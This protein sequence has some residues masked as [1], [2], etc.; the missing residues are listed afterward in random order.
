MKVLLVSAEWVFNNC[1]PPFHKRTGE[2]QCISCLWHNFNLALS[3]VQQCSSWFL[4]EAAAF[5]TW[6][7]FI[8][9]GD[10]PSQP[11]R[12]RALGVHSACKES[13]PTSVVSSLQCGNEHGAGSK[14]QNFRL[15]MMKAR[16]GN[17]ISSSIIWNPQLLLF[18]HPNHTPSPG[19]AAPPTPQVT[20]IPSLNYAHPTEL[21]APGT[22]KKPIPQLAD[23]S[24]SGFG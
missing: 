3:E 15:Q 8:W 4:V 24:R 16:L 7:W 18:P 9:A 13:T 14:T 11:Q 10:V 21:R 19:G 5:W 12:H 2:V 6:G 17:R 22:Q 1:P 23:E 20:P